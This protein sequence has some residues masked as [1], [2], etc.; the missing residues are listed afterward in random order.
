MTVFVLVH[1]SWGGAWQWSAVARRLRAAGHEVSA[2]TLTGLGERAHAV[3]DGITL[4][5]HIEDVV[6]H[7]W[8]EDLVD[9]VLVG[10]SY[11]GAVV[12][13]AADRVPERLKRV[14]NLDGMI[15]QEG[16][17]LDSSAGAGDGRGWLPAPTATDLAQVLSD[18]ALCEFVAERER[19]DPVGGKTTAYPDLGG[20]RWSVPHTY[21]ECTVVPP[22]EELDPED[23]AT[24]ERVNS[25]DRWEVRQLPVNHLGLLYAPDLVADVLMDVGG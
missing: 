19:P 12:D 17:A 4:L 13:G 25:D 5:T 3:S 24:M 7:L 22:G 20:G 15:A 16:T 9:V 8:F 14:V 23:F 21:L 2:P 11:G 6:Q 1:G 10:W 18:P